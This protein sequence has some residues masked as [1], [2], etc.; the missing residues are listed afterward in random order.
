MDYRNFQLDTEWNRV[1]LPYKPNG[2][3]I[4]V[5]GDDRHYVDEKSSYWEQNEGKRKL[6]KDWVESGYTVFYSNLYGANWG[7]DQ[8]AD[9]AVTLCANVKRKE[10]LNERFHI[11]AEGM[12]A[13][14]A[15]K[16]VKRLPSVRS[17]LLINPVLSLREHLKQ[18]R[19]HK[20]FYKKLV[21]E[22]STSRSIH[23]K[24]VESLAAGE[25]IHANFS[26]ELPVR[27]IQVLSGSR[28][29]AQSRILKQNS[30]HWTEKGQSVSICYLLPE[31]KPQIGSMT[32]KFFHQHEQIL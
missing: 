15:Y 12:G 26:D 11:V 31:K 18:E 30:L 4:L 24:D 22:I 32:M 10:I 27:I 5:I 2:F 21:K 6:L 7:S 9:L 8:A 20:F 29:H 3:G 1:W 13:L 25:D 17:L 19:D 14:T 16:L 23:P 28:G